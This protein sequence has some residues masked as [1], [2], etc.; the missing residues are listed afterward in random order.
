MEG[1]HDASPGGP[2]LETNTPYTRSQS[3]ASFVFDVLQPPTALGSGTDPPRSARPP[4][5]GL[6]GTGTMSSGEF[7]SYVIISGGT[8]C[9]AICSAFGENACYVLPVS[10]NGGS[11]SE[12]IRVLAI[13][14]DIRSRL[15]RLIP[16]ASSDSPTERIRHLLSYRFPFEYTERVAREAWRDIVEGRSS[17][18][19]GIPSDR[20]ET[21]RGFL[22]YFD[23]EVLKRA[24]KQFS[25]RNA[26]IGNFFLTGAHLFFRSI[27]SA[28][29]L[30][31]SITGSKADV[32]PVLVTNH[33][34][35]IAAKLKN[36]GTLVGQ[37]EISH[38]PTS[39]VAPH[40][41]PISIS[42]SRIHYPGGCSALSN[43]NYAKLEDHQYDPLDS[44]IERIF[45]IN[46]YGQ[47]VYPLPNPQ[48]LKNLNSRFTLVY[49]CGSLFTS[50]IPCLALRGVGP[51]IANSHT[52]RAKVLL[53]NGK[54]DR[55]TD[56]FTATDYIRAIS[57]QLNFC[58][59]PN[60]Q[61]PMRET[62]YP[63]S[64]FITHLV[65]LKNSAVKVDRAEITSLGVGCVEIEGVG[66]CFDA[67]SVEEALGLI[68]DSLPFC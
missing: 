8:G 21:I 58:Q 34:V 10:D 19:S 15:L 38:P 18:W 57:K 26:S 53:L 55:E 35:T 67:Q 40:M 12:I 14:G 25:F 68:Q 59:S 46:Q 47:E 2:Y 31:S 49:S 56:G 24:N 9:N 17:L 45:Y 27:P 30:M 66:Q 20:K 22:V 36:G 44:P 61:M 48:F 4:A 65:Y 51:A 28:I 62:S 6:S 33:T 37:C 1:L 13:K 43:I 16:P 50:I 23:G 42:T 7:L 52:L 32:L 41:A 64:A 29:F 5:L 11:S 63:V 54:N 39:L 60:P 3:V